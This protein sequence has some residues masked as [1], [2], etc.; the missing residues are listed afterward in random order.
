MRALAISLCLAA[1]A[2]AQTPDAILTDLWND[3]SSTCAPF[4]ANPAAAMA[5][6]PTNLQYLRQEQSADGRV[7]RR[8]QGRWGLG[9]YR[10]IELAIGVESAHVY[11]QIG[12][13]S[14]DRQFNTDAME[15]T[16]RRIL[17]ADGSMRLAG[18]FRTIT[19]SDPNEEAEGDVDS[20]SQTFKKFLLEGA[21]GD[22]ADL[23]LI[24]MSSPQVL[25]T[26]SATVP[27]EERQ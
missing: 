23:I 5:R 25:F 21:L 27:L 26:V 19:L 4:L 9:Q 12:R 11:C 15:T 7:F 1:P 14:P 10:L 6:S 24:E 3:F 22:R 18:G 16:L 17:P 2:A 8:Y 20:V 13:T